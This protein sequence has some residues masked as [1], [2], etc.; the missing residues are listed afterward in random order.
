MTGRK[1]SQSLSCCYNQVLKAE[2]FINLE[3]Y[4]PRGS[5][6][7]GLEEHGVAFAQRLEGT[8]YCHSMVEHIMQGDKESMLAQLS[9]FTSHSC[10]HGGPTDNHFPKASAPSTA[11]KQILEVLDI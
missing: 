7:R 3:V 1:V 5:G 2:R 4:L 11:H 9:F 6:W 8:F 10:Q